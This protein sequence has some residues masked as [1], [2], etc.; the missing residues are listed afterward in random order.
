MSRTTTTLVFAALAA[1]VAAGPASAQSGGDREPAG[2]AFMSSYAGNPQGSAAQ[3][4]SSDL[5]P[6][7]SAAEPDSTGSL[8]RPQARPGRRA[9]R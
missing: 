5:A 9:P 7:R 8:G 4:R 2:G 6:A 1:A 3:P